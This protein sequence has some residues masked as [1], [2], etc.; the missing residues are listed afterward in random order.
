MLNLFD[1]RTIMGCQGGMNT[2]RYT[3]I[4]IYARFWGQFFFNVS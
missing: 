4:S 2:I 1:L 3:R